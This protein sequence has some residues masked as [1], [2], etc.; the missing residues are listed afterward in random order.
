MNQCAHATE[1]NNCGLF[2]MFKVAGVDQSSV[3][4]PFPYSCI[5]VVTGLNTS[6]HSSHWVCLDSLLLLSRCIKHSSTTAVFIDRSKS[7]S[8]CLL[9]LLLTHWSF[10]GAHINLKKCKIWDKK[11]KKLGTLLCE[12]KCKVSTGY[13]W[14]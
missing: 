13:I 2:R 1:L 7:L 4:H 6:I 9:P 11:K 12:Y 14:G 5:N 3:P 8:T 10:I